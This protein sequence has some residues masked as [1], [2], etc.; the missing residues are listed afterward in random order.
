MFKRDLKK[1]MGLQSYNYLTTASPEFMVMAKIWNIVKRGLRTLKHY[2]SIAN[3]KN[4]IP[5]YFGAK[6]FILNMRNY[7]SGHSITC[8]NWYNK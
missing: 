8:D 6:K 4:E 1:I 2:T 5:T 3:L 7:I